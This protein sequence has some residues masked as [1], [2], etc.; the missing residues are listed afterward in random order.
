[1]EGR[2]RDD[3]AGVGI[4]VRRGGIGGTLT[5]KRG[6]TRGID[7][8]IDLIT[9]RWIGRERDTR[10]ERIDLRSTREEEMMIGHRAGGGSGVIRQFH[11]DGGEIRGTE[12]II[13]E[14]EENELRWSTCEFNLSTFGVPSWC[15]CP[16][17][18]A[19]LR[20]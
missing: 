17:T 2:R 14:D 7:R 10:I 16:K 13:T 6:H 15:Q 8:G 4:G 12:V 18:V 1:M 3:A 9:D 11:L 19:M 20:A 5:A